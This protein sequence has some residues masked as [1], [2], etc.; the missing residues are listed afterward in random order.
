[1][2]LS[3]NNQCVLITGASS[4]IGQSCA[5]LLAQA[6]ARLILAARRK[7]KLKTLS[8]ELQE[9]YQTQTLLLCVDVQERQTVTTALEGL[10]AAWKSIDVLINNA[11]LSRG[12]EKQYE[13][14]VQDWEEM[15]DTNM[16]GLLY[17]TRAV[18][19]GMV[20]RGRGHVVNIGS[21]A[22]R[23]TYTGGSVYCATKAAV[24][25]LSEGL[26]IDLLGTPVRVT[27]IEPGLVE[28]EFSNVRFRGDDHRANS[29]YTGMTPLTPD[30]IADTIVFA[31]TRPAHV[32]ISEIFVMPTD[33]SSVTHVHRRTV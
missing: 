8:D 17:V 16:K 20:A 23:Q 5:R 29:V 12:L 28:T 13:S 21:I 6:G 4:G 31:V 11:G 19:P 14:P 22:A 33:Q 32:N 15:I 7:E 9:K 3:L 2:A 30:D 1:M 18:V 26:K 25:S 24:K 27:N 10:P